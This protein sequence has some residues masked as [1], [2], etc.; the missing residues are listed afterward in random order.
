MKKIKVHY[1]FSKNKKIGSK[2]IAWGTAHRCDVDDVPS[3]VAILVEER[4]V[5]ESTLSS[6]VRVIP[7]KKWKEINT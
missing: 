5:Y 1:L 6:G 2:L 7:Y 3:H 4:W